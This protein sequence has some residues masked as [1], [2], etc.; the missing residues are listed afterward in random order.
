MQLSKKKIFLNEFAK[1]LVPDVSVCITDLKQDLH[2]LLY[3]VNRT[4]RLLYLFSLKQNKVSSTLFFCLLSYFIAFECLE[5]TYMYL[6]MHP[7]K[8]SL[9]AFSSSV[10]FCTCIYPTSAFCVH[11][12]AFESCSSSV[13]IKWYMCI[14]NCESEFTSDF[15]KFCLIKSLVVKSATYIQVTSPLS[16]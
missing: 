15:M 8:T 13:M 14:M 2:R 16:Q 6:S 5:W 4:C 11:S 12:T 7:V 1:S 10:Q 3:L 9:C